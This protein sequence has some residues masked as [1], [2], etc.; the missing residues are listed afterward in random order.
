[1][2]EFLVAVD[3]PVRLAGPV[4]EKDRSRALRPALLEAAALAARGFSS[5]P[6]LRRGASVA[7]RWSSCSLRLRDRRRIASGPGAGIRRRPKPHLVT[8][9]VAPIPV[10][11][12]EKELKFPPLTIEFSEPAARLEDLKNPALAACAARSADPGA[13]K[14]TNDRKLV[15]APAPGLAGRSQIPHRFRQGI[16]P[17]ARAHGEAGTRHHDPAVQGRDQERRLCRKTPRSRACSASSPRS[18]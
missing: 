10:T 8:A 11:P 9:Q 1:M 6:Y 15:F 18:S 7:G 17:V 5:R 12:L 2:L 4:V 3:S 16:F 13:W 14:W